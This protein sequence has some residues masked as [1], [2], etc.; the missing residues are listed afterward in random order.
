MSLIDDKQVREFGLHMF[1]RGCLFILQGKSHSE[2]IAAAME[3]IGEWKEQ[4]DNN[5]KSVKE[6]LNRVLKQS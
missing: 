4:E 1:D 3:A 2:Y 6:K 5:K